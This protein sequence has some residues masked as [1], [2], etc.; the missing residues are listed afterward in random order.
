MWQK[1]KFINIH[2]KID[3]ITLSRFYWLTFQTFVSP[4][5]YFAW[6]QTLCYPNNSRNQQNWLRPTTNTQACF[7]TQVKDK[8]F[9]T[10]FTWIFFIT[11]IIS[12]ASHILDTKI[13][14]A[15][16]VSTARVFFWSSSL[17]T[18]ANVERILRLSWEANLFILAALNLNLPHNC[19]CSSTIYNKSMFTTKVLTIIKQTARKLF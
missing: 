3:C 10:A 18:H 8:E 2:L 5:R 12:V 13:Y 14:L 1:Y 6:I 11:L 16:S 4:A 15:I 7:Y 9:K 19:R 17:I